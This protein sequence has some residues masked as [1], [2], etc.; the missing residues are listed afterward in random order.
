[1]SQ[2]PVDSHDELNPDKDGRSITLPPVNIHPQDERSQAQH[3]EA[4]SSNAPAR[5]AGEQ[6]AQQPSTPYP[7][8]QSTDGRPTRPPS[9]SL[10]V[11]NIL[12]PAEPEDVKP[13]PSLPGPASLAAGTSEQ[14]HNEADPR[15]ST[16]QK[17]GL[18][19]PSLSS[20]EGSDQLRPR[21]TLYPK[22]PR[23][24]S[25]GG[26]GTGVF[27]QDTKQQAGSGASTSAAVATTYMATP[28]T[29]AGA[30]TPPMPTSHKQTPYSYLP[31]AGSTP[32]IDSRRSSAATAPSGLSQSQTTS[33]NISYFSYSLQPSPAQPP[34]LTQGPWTPSQYQPM[35]SQ[36][37][38]GLRSSQP[39][40]T[41]Q[42]EGPYMPP[43][44]GSHLSM[45][46]G[47]S[48]AALAVGGHP[49]AGGMQARYSVP[50]DRVSGSRSAD[51]KRKHNAAASSRFRERRK[52]LNEELKKE[53]DEYAK[54]NKELEER[55]EQ[56]ERMVQDTGRQRDFYRDAYNRLVGSGGLGLPHPSIGP[57]PYVPPSYGHS[58]AGTGP[59][60]SGEDERP[61]QR[62]R[63]QG[64]EQGETYTLPPATSYQPPPFQPRA[65]DGRPQSLHPPGPPR[66]APGSMSAPSGPSP[67][68]R[69]PYEQYPPAT[70]GGGYFRGQH[71]G[72]STPRSSQPPFSSQPPPAGEQRR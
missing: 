36:S 62:R 11:R 28:G 9:R 30:P 16:R 45:P 7:P 34:L 38:G 2:R 41:Q 66:S 68:P 24:M 29:Y 55:V 4:S 49:S 56:L 25:L 52:K 27:L 32:P 5:P 14:A 39:A 40:A 57:A 17:R 67:M 15:P 50:V 6:Y 48:G 61:A 51:E 33:P 44:H 63:T 19:S 18:Q 35:T 43:M 72:P 46:G 1:M 13:S 64:P 42:Q 54:K 20:N 12:N 10:G 60:P 71:S 26:G 3:E 31:P 47:L 65:D 23:S 59:R 58:S 37:M 8:L 70:N 53:N 22:S 69:S 21:K